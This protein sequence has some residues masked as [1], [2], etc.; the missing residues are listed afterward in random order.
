MSTYE[1]IPN[2][3]TPGDPPPPL[4]KRLRVLLSLSLLSLLAFLLS[5]S[6]APLTVS[7]LGAPVAKHSLLKAPTSAPPGCTASVLLLRHCE[8]LNLRQYCTVLGEQRAL[9]L[10]TQ[11]GDG[12]GERW[13]APELLYARPPE[14]GKYVMREIELLTPL[15]DKFG[16][17][18]RS[19][20]FGIRHKDKMAEEIFEGMRSGETCGGLVVVSWKHENI[21]KLARQMGCGPLEGCPER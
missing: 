19:A 18:I 21:P 8:G 5:P 20:G 3:D 10:A 13:P 14:K 6:S 2:T 7:L 16:L 4:S 11:F 1:T 12:A 9:F 17:E 15:A